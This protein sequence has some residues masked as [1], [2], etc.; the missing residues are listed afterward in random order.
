MNE[1]QVRRGEASR[2][3]SQARNGRIGLAVALGLVA[4]VRLLRG[5]SSLWLILAVALGLAAIGVG[6][7]LLRW[8]RSC[9]TL[10]AK[11]RDTGQLAGA[12]DALPVKF[13]PPGQPGPLEVFRPSYWRQV[14]PAALV[15][16][17]DRIAIRPDEKGRAKGWSNLDIRPSRVSEV[18]I[19]RAPVAAA[20]AW[21]Y[22]GLTDGS[23]LSFVTTETD[24]LAAVLRALRVPVNPG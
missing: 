16:F 21:V 7:Y 5:G 23:V 12:W 11:L 20:G 19:D 8:Q 3:A 1:R 10:L 15:V 17:Q 4:V 13:Q 18:V 22:L 2:V 14:Y 6:L 24:R 9:E